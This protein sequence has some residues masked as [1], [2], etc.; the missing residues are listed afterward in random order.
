MDFLENQNIEIYGYCTFSWLLYVFSDNKV[1]EQE[2]MYN[3]YKYKSKAVLLSLGV[4]PIRD[5]EI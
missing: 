4:Y 2:E 3:N 1:V 5:E